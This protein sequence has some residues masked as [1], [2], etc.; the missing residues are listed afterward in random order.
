MLAPSH[1]SMYLLVGGVKID[2]H[3]RV[4]RGDDSLIEGIYAAGEVSGGVHGA[5][6]LG[7]NSLAEC[8]VFG[9]VAAHGAVNQLRTQQ[10]CMSVP[11]TAM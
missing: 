5:N 3:A 6:R 10:N 8:V 7:G 11:F 9:R 1:G 4:L 2:E